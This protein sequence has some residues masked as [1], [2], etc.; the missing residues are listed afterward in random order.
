MSNPVGWCDVT[1]NPIVGCTKDCKDPEGRSYCYARNVSA[2]AFWPHLH[3]WRLEQP[4]HWRKPRRILCGSMCDLWDPHVQQQWRD[5]VWEAMAAVPQHRFLVVTKRPENILWEDQLEI[6][7]NPALW[8]GVTVEA[9]EFCHRPETLYRSTKTER[10]FVSAEPLFVEFPLSCR[11]NWLILGVD[12]RRKPYL[13]PRG[14][15]QAMVKQADD[16]GIPVFVKSNVY[17]YFPDAPR[18][19]EFPEGLL[20]PGEREDGEGV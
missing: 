10:L 11:E 1:W 14:A 2:P 12:S 9:G 15:I 20:L 8:V 16:L 18:R 5:R 4:L 19:Q 6:W 7:R 13:P 17:K 3:K